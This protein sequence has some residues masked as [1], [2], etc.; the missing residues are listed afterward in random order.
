MIVFEKVLPFPIAELDYAS[1]SV[2]D[3]NDVSFERGKLYLIR[4]T[5]GKG[6][7]TLLSIIYG[8][9]NDYSGTALFDNR[10]IRMFSTMERSLLR[11][12]KLSYLFQGLRLFSDLTGFEN[13]EI[14][15]KQTNFKSKNEIY[16]MSEMLG[17]RKCLDKIVIKLSF[18]QR[19]R[20]ALLR[21]LCQPYEY[22]LLDEP[23]SHL[24]KENQKTGCNLITNE[25][26][27]QG[28]GLLLSS[29]D[30]RYDIEYDRTYEV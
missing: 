28:A 25:C 11:Q 14:N 23:F 21:S 24:D 17:I 7:T 1:S 3:K 29:L 15:N 13:I 22:L 4:S 8:I 20:I 10:D 9:R 26:K 6:K 19:Q 5:S 27:K 2:W 18:G 30:S 12:K 16:K